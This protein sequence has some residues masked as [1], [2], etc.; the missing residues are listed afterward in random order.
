MAGVLQ[1]A[2]CGWRFVAGVLRPAICGWRFAVGDLRLLF[3]GRRFAVGAL[4]LSFCG[5]RFAVVVL[6]LSFCGCRFAVG[7]LQL[8]FCGRRFWVGVLCLA[9][10]GW[11]FTIDVCLSRFLAGVLRFPFCGWH[12]VVE[13]LRLAFCGWCLRLAF[14]R[15]SGHLIQ[16]TFDASFTNCASRKTVPLV[17]TGSKNKHHYV[18]SSFDQDKRLS[19]SITVLV[20]LHLSLA[21]S[22]DMNI[23]LSGKRV[24]I[25]GAGRG[26]G[27]ALAMRVAA[28]GGH[29]IALS[30]T[31]AHLDTLQ[32][33]C[34]S[35]EMVTCDLADWEATRAAVEALEPVHCLVNNAGV[36]VRKP[37]FEVTQSDID[38]MLNVN[39]KAV[40]NVSQV[41][42]HGMV[43]RGEGGVIINMSSE[44]AKRPRPV[45]AAYCTSKAA[46]DHLTR[47]MAL[48]LGPK[49]IRVNSVRPTLV[50][51]DI[52]R[53]VWEDPQKAANL[54]KDIPM[55]RFAEVDDVVSATVFLL[56]DDASL[57][58]G[59]TL[60]VDGGSTAI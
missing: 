23:S 57:I 19:H 5:C 2:F 30:R 26:I 1:P 38:F 37:F 32:A 36:V 44:A 12:F 54:L 27:R 58:S 52:G 43:A 47:G 49:G 6:W 17:N 10:C 29:V 7:D 16:S 15:F 34:A 13:V 59:I 3:C 51:T 14:L 56:S 21:L 35:L 33:E 46:L 39:L 60:P 50:K 55:G 8:T 53:P 24:L 11:R 25:T 4:R 48:E 18:H 9:F 42:A 40:I 31:Q 28:C 45:G 41:V 20:D 22:A